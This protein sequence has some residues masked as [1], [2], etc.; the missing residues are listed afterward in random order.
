MPSLNL[1]D[2]ERRVELSAWLSETGYHWAGQE[3]EDK[4]LA[5]LYDLR[6][7]P[8]TDG[9]AAYPTAAEDIHQHQVRNRDWDDDWVF[10]DPRFNLWHC[11]DEEFLKFLLNTLR[12]RTQPDPAV[13]ALMAAQYNTV[14][15]PTGWE[16]IDDH[17]VGES[18]YYAYR[19]RTGVHD[20]GRVELTAPDVVD[21][22]VLDQQLGRLRRDIETDPAAAIAHCKE[23]IESQLKLV[24]QQFG[25]QYSDRD[26]VPAL[27]GQVSR[28]L[29]IHSNAVPGDSRASEAVKQ[30]LRNLSSVVK[31]ISE[32]RNA[33][34]TGH[35]RAE[36]SPAERRHARLFFNATV[37]VTEF[38]AE[39]WAARE[40][41]WDTVDPF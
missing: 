1:I 19:R 24:L 25:E 17:H 9:R 38:I 6:Q 10:G 32:A 16:F 41:E 31:N 28:R 29:G 3:D 14:L 30:V 39:T 11:S 12:P 18:V 37:T 23:L 35:G 2:R 4:F 13:T 21:R 33:M 27:Y 26:D 34:G 15:A 20:P 22:F 40:D 36:A 8:S 7:M 5:R